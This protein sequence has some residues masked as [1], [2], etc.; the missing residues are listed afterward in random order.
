[1]F[2]SLNTENKII[3]ASMISVLVLRISSKI[4]QHRRWLSGME[5]YGVQENTLQ[6]RCCT[7]IE[8]L[9][10]EQT[11]LPAYEGHSSTYK[12]KQRSRR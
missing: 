11:F 2:S 4:S 5:A 12:M 6:N 8:E 7:I 3:P 9:V 10:S 1:M